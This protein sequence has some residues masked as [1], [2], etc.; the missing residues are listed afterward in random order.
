M[1]KIKKVID[2]INESKIINY[3]TTSRPMK[4][5]N[6]IETEVE[7]RENYEIDD[8]EEWIEKYNI[9]ENSKLLW[10]T[11]KPWIAARYEMS[12]DDWDNAEEIYNNNSNDYN[13]ETISSKIGVIIDE[14]DDGDD[15][16]LM[17]LK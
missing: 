10:V 8:V 3:Y 16:F 5:E 7:D 9:D 4:M 14:S 6:F 17:L 1:G 15:G 12:S 11:T 2:F 13:V